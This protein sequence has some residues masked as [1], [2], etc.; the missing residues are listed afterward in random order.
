[1]GGVTGTLGGA[2]RPS[3]ARIA[4]AAARWRRQL[5]GAPGVATR[6]MA[7]AHGDER[8]RISSSARMA[9]MRG[10]EEAT[11]GA[12]AA[13]RRTSAQDRGV[14]SAYTR[15]VVP[16]AQSMA[17]GAA[18]HSLWCSE[19]TR[20][21][22]DVRPSQLTIGSRWRRAGRRHSGGDAVHW[23]NPELASTQVR[24]SR[25]RSRLRCRP[26]AHTPAAVGS[27]L[28]RHPAIAR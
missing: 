11:G 6:A 26:R 15:W 24:R 19:Q 2:A 20:Q 7:A 25:A 9:S 8:A 10:D 14:W 5:R 16:R 1:M 3:A 4:E 17:Q 28:S 12:Q 18:E 22:H 13:R 21:H 23:M 27:A